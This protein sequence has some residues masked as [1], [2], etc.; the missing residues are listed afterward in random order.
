MLVT[1]MVVLA[2]LFVPAVAFNATDPVSIGAAAL[3]VGILAVLI[4][5]GS[6]VEAAIAHGVLYLFGA[7]GLTRTLEAFAYP[8]IVRN[9]LW[10]FPLVN[11]GVGLYG[12]YLQIRAL[13][14]FHDVSAGK[15][16][17]AA[18]LAAILYLPA[19]VVL[20]AV[21]GAFVLGLGGSTEPTGAPATALVPVLPI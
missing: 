18:V 9:G 20:A 16:A 6:V 11:I 14:A 5:I 17:V 13:A 19:I 2:P 21:L 15:A 3:V 1:S 8:M 4:W 10:W 12:L 7:R